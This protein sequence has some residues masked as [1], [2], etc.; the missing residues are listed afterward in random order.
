MSDEIERRISERDEQVYTNLVMMI[1]EGMDFVRYTPRL[2][3]FS[4][5]GMRFEELPEPE[6]RVGQSV[7]VEFWCGDPPAQRVI[8]G[9]IVWVT[10]NGGKIEFG[11]EFVDE[12]D[13]IVHPHS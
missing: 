3:D 1:Q 11:V 13:D 4:T 2:L 5:T 12:Q 7:I 9:T 8:D 6:I 10:D